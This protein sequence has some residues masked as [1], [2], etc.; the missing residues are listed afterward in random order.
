MAMIEVST[1]SDTYRED[2]QVQEEIQSAL[3]IFE[4]LSLSIS[5]WYIPRN[6]M[7][8]QFS[9]RYRIVLTK[10]WSLRPWNVNFS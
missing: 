10:A 6:D 1:T 8:F 7:Q 5:E 9:V 4:L 3:S 2:A